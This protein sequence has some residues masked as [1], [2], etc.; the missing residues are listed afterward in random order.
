M[1]AAARDAAEAQEARRQVARL[2]LV[3]ASSHD[4]IFSRDLEGV[5]TSWNAAAEALYGYSAEEAI[6]RDGTILLTPSHEGETKALIKRMLQ[7]DRGFGFETQHLRRDGSQADV[8]LSLSPVRDAAGAIT[9]ITVIARDVSERVRAERELRESEEKFAAAFHASP[10]LMMITR[11]SD[12]LLLEV[13]EGFTHLLGYERA[14]TVGRTTAELSIW[15]DPQSRAA[16]V[17]SLEASGATGETE[18]ILRRNDGTAITGVHSAR[19]MAVR[20]EA[21][22]L[23]VVHDVTERKQ[24]EHRA[25][26]RAKE[27][28]A[29]YALAEMAQREGLTLDRL[30]QGLTDILPESWQYPEIACARTVIGEREFRTNNFM[31]SAWMQ[32]APVTVSGSAVG[33]I[34]VGY[35]EEMPEEDEGP[36]L[37]E[38]RRLIDALAERLGQIIEREQAEEALRGSESQY[39]GLFEGMSQ[40]V[41]L[42]SGDGEIVS[43]NPAAERILGLSLDQMRGRTSVDARWRAV[44]EDGSDFPGEEHPSMVALRTGQPVCDVVMGVWDAGR[45]SCRWIEIN[46]VPHARPAGGEP[47]EVFATFDDITER[48]QAEEALRE[49]EGLLRG[50]FDNMPS[51]AGIYEVRGDGSRGSDYIIKD[52][53]AAGLRIEGKT[54]EE[55]VGK[56]LFDL[57]PAIDEYG[58]IPVLQG[59]WQTGEPALFPTA[60][61]SDGHHANWYENR[62]FRLPSGEV[63]AIYDDVTESREAEGRLSES[64]ARYRGYVDNA[65]YGVF[66]TDE[67]GRYL[68]GNQ[69]AAELTGYAP[70][71]LA[72]LGIPGVVAPE[73]REWAQQHFARVLRTGRSSG[74]GVFLRKDG[75][76]LPVRV[77]AVRLSAT[78]FLGF[79]ADVSEQQRAAAEIEA[80]AAQVKQA[81]TATVAALSATTEL[82]DPYTAGHQRRV[83]ELAG[84]I[85]AGLGW[86]EARVEMLETAGLL[87]DV[88]KLVVPA[89]ILARPG[90]LSETEMQ[91]VRGHAAA[92][93]ALIAGI[94]FGGPVA[95]IVNQH[96]ERLDGSGYP[97]RLKGE[98][99]LPEARVLAVADVVEAMSSHRPYRPA[100]GMEVALAEVREHAGE[101]YDADVVAACGRL[102]EEEGFQFTP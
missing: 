45:D 100:L 50:L 51:G 12:G 62:V 4:A 13:N 75:T 26:E 14:E 78:R 69:A 95:A 102:I 17:A 92:S 36:F 3:A 97:Q 6:G 91:L 16:F 53:N 82:R 79:V 54:R 18:T 84:A 99:I 74:E 31:E 60:F 19:S 28:R 68:E 83:A 33:R 80:S 15:A 23:S 35:R 5:I 43:A 101:K 1:F 48:K 93:A 55:V 56:S 86:D 76:S 59:V 52:F 63:V 8:A 47:Y 37:K 94:E 81:L 90:R 70:E 29:L 7:G 58:L 9:G 96:H 46:A 98:N 21:S 40:G 2:A 10:D 30:Y 38:E 61:Y 64:E 57:R 24:A 25:E 89:E 42:Q 27:L 34:D 49:S 32:S 22:I 85:A 66:V 39:R 20:G 67:T 87:H 73:S 41:V 65:P 77:D 72:R 71:E 11:L 88:G 44:H